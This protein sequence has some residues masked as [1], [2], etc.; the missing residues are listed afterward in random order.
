MNMV[1]IHARRVSKKNLSEQRFPQTTVSPHSLG[2][3]QLFAVLTDK[4]Q[5]GE[6]EKVGMIL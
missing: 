2:E 6:D 4:D 3:K 1:L 5:V